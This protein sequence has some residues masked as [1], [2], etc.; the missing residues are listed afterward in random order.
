LRSRASGAIFSDPD[1]AR[2]FLHWGDQTIVIHSDGKNDVLNG[3]SKN[4]STY[5]QFNSSHRREE[6]KLI[7]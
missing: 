1:P 4:N 5:L 2:R 6:C 3:E 7:N